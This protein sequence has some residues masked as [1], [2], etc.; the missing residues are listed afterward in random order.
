MTKILCDICGKE[1]KTVDIT[2]Q[3]KHREKEYDLCAEHDKKLWREALD[4]V[5]EK[6]QTR[7]SEREKELQYLEEHFGR[8]ELDLEEI[9]ATMARIL[10]LRI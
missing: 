1:I 3:S 4:T 8:K 2:L 9:V 6:E 10:R 7:I 5:K